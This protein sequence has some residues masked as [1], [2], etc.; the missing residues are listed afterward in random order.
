MN[1][2]IKFVILGFMALELSNV[3][4]LYF[5]PGSKMGNAVGVFTAWEKSKEYPMIHDF[6]KYLVYWVAG[7][8]LI[9]I[10]LLGIIVFYGNLNMQQ[11][12]LIALGLATLTFF[13]RL[14]P[15]IRKMDKN[16]QVEPKNYSITLGAMILGL[17][18]LFAVA[19]IIK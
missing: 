9:F 5:A 14:F 1:M 19:A 2:L 18:A 13:W 8:K 10:L 4:F 6:V 7:V 15:L 12:S 16:G 17:V 11:L 3:F